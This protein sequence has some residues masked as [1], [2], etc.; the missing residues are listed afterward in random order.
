MVELGLRLGQSQVIAQ[1]LPCASLS[2]WVF[3]KAPEKSGGQA[4]PIICLHPDGSAW[5]G[6]EH[7]PAP[8]LVN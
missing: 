7:R 5:H 8:N 6:A 1:K 3:C 4:V 2:S